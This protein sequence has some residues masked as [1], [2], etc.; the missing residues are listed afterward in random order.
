MS[1]T[2]T[3]EEPTPS[4]RQTLRE[5][6]QGSTRDLT[7]I[8]VSRA[9]ALLA[10][11]MV[12]EM[13][14]ESLFAI[15]DIFWV[16]R[17]G[18]DA[19]AIVGLTESMLAI[20]YALAMGLSAGA[21]AIVS[22]RIGEGDKEG[23]ARAVIQILVVGLIAAC[24]IGALGVALAPRLLAAMG[25]SEALVAQGSEYTAVMLGGSVTVL[26]LFLINAVFRGAGDA[27]IAMRVLW[28][29]NGLNIV[30]APLL[31]FGVGPF[32]ELGVTG[33]AVA[34]TIC[35][36]IGVLFQLTVLFRGKRR[37]AVSRRHVGFDADL[38]KRFF[39]LSG[40]ATLQSLVETSSWLGLVR[41]LATFGSPA[42]AGYTLAIRIAMF[43]LLPSF[44]I[45]NAAAT[46]VGQNLG[47]GRPE[48]AERSV[49][50]AGRWNFVFLGTVSVLF[51]FAPGWLVGLFGADPAAVPHAVDCLRILSLG[52]LFYAYGFVAVM[53]FNGA[54]DVKTPMLLNLACFWAIKIPLAWVLAV[55]CGLGTRG[56]FIAVSVAYS[57]LA[58]AALILFKRGKWKQTVV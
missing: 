22:R 47:A 9:V 52:F 39:G 26:L 34:T 6:L 7:T 48:R 24:L 42:L 1:A 55:P 57:S 37:L 51:V 27:A 32:P 3:A 38:L 50:V 21:T 8:G 10:I 18:S 30:L 15:A 46:L 49:W 44:G 31:I 25:A 20:V 45:A 53:A 35:R 19:V 40:G 33:A 16:S 43:A 41:I 4:L 12:A 5:A 14:M 29:A 56:V 36:G 23:A 28:L 17:L 54:G 2:E 11:P 13:F 58:V